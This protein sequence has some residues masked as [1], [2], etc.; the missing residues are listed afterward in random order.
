MD[1]GKLL[2]I[3]RYDI[4]SKF[5]LNDI[6]ILSEKY[7]I[8]LKEVRVFNNVYIIIAFL[9]EFL[10]LLFNVW[11]YKI[12][13]IWFA[14]YHSFL[15]VLFCKI[16]GIK[17]IICAGG[18]ESTYIPEINT[19]VFIRSTFSQ[20]IRL[21]CV[22][23]SLNNCDI[24]LTVDETLIHNIN[25]YI[26]SDIHGKKPLEDGIKFF[27]PDLKAKIAAVHLG[28]DPQIFRKN[29]RVKNEYSVL[30]AGLIVNDNEYRRKG[31]D[32]LIEAS[33][34]MQDVKFVVVGLSNE[35]IE[36]L[37]GL[38]L[39]NVELIGKVS[40][41]RLIE[42]YS[43]AKVFAQISMFEGMPSTI[44]EAMLC[45]CVPVGSNVNGIPK[46][47]DKFGYVI[48]KRNLNEIV[49]KLY[50]ALNANEETALKAREHI[51]NNFSINRRKTSLL[52]IL[53]S[54]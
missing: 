51:I 38:N 46:I 22:K 3:K 47:I 10:Y 28:Y 40:Y 48:E 19:G 49:E 14:D 52:K 39:K 16:T 6:D 8:T 7:K 18:Y 53:E 29:E 35:Y 2:F 45:E 36:L 13:Y 17:S 42:E 31:I 21:F 4:N 33:K 20:K 43:K 37:S 1:K 11:R 34:Q 30:T 25:T 9:K 15:P 32:L 54:L 23:F 12:V 27:I 24:I 26:Y 41:E 5:V 44:C 50:K